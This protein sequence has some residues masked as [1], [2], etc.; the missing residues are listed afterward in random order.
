[1]QKTCVICKNGFEAKR[2]DVLYC[3]GKCK[4]SSEY[5]RKEKLVKN[6]KHCG[7]TFETKRKDTKYCSSS[8]SNTVCKAHDDVTL[9]CKECG[10]DFIKK[11][12]HR[13]KLFCS[14]SCATVHQNNIMF[15]DDKVRNK[16]AETHKRQLQTGE[17]V[18]P[19]LGKNLTSEHK[20]KISDTR[21]INKI[22]AGLNNPS[23]GKTREKSPIYGIKRSEETKETM[24]NIKAQQWIDGKYNGVDFNKF[25]KNGFMYSEK[26]KKDIWYRSGLERQIFEKIEK[27]QNIITYRIEP[28]VIKYFYTSQKQN[29]NYI[30]DIL[31]FYK[32]GEIKLI[33]LKPEYQL[34]E[35]KNIDKF[36]AAQKYCNEKGM[37]FEVWTEKNNPYLD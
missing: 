31:C 8:C 36:S 15:S 24:S 20:R 14:R 35:Q 30:P 18:H 23:Y 28:F 1:M 11:Y 9:S 6:C 5:L 34:E 16:I 7:Q 26:C 2:K 33:E 25:Y 22:A 37:I 32:N 21:I 13:D 10:S 29:R 19:F 27:D 3:S 4:K 12:I 17:R